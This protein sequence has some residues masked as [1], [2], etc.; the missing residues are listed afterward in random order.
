MK[1]PGRRTLAAGL[2]AGVS[3]PGCTDMGWLPPNINGAYGGTIDGLYYKIM[4]VVAVAFFVTE[5]LLVYSIVR[6]RASAGR[7][8][9]YSHGSKRT[10]LL[11]SIVPGFILIWLALVQK[12]A[13]FHIRSEFPRDADAL[14]VQVM[15][16]QF[17]WNF[18]YAGKDGKF[19]IDDPDATDDVVSRGNLHIPVNRNVVTRMSSKDVIHSFFLPYLRVKQDVLPGM[20]T[21]VWFAANRIGA[22]NLKTHRLEL[23]T[24]EEFERA[25]VGLPTTFARGPGFTLRY[26]VR[27]PATGR[28]TPQDDPSGAGKRKTGRRDLDYEPPRAEKVPIARGG[29]VEELPWQEAGYVLHPLEIAC[30]ELCGNNHFTMRG[31]LWVEPEWL[32]L[33]WL[34]G[35]AA[36]QRE[37]GDETL[38]LWM[39]V[40]DAQ[41][42][43]Y[44]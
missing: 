32:F 41:H 14:V 12:D 31:M 23:L 36:D 20:L 29:K 26:G 15:P 2:A 5:G 43:A 24:P 3:L 38:E 33:R 4:V 35:K 17:K 19:G 27:D 11:W 28:F 16:E 18:R 44:N 39:N 7:K 10:E 40:W 34:E 30:A 9:V 22:W 8:A 37:N 42:R 21:R 1:T 13:W 25:K 6:F